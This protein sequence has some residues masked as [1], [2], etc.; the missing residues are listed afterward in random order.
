MDC[1]VSSSIPLDSLEPLAKLLE[2]F[3]D[4]YELLLLGRRFAVGTEQ[5]L[6]QTGQRYLDGALI[7]VVGTCAILQETKQRLLLGL[8]FRF[9]RLPLLLLE[10][11]NRTN[12]NERRDPCSTIFSLI[13]M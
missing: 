5:T 11:L 9:F 1:L 7:V 2:R 8:A 4:R 10:F 3:R 12:G 6:E 13:L